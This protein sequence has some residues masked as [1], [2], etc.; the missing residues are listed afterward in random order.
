[1]GCPTCEARNSKTARF[2]NSCGELIRIDPGFEKQYRA[3][4]AKDRRGRWVKATARWGLALTILGVFGYEFTVREVKLVV[5]ASA[6]PLINAAV[7]AEVGKQLETQ[8]PVAVAQAES[9]GASK[10][11]A[12]YQRA[13]DDSVAK[14]RRFDEHLAALQKQK[15]AEVL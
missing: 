8:I 14:G 13:V 10:V 7:T 9:Q 2:C 11:Q 4:Q 3:I 5:D 6:R 1:M 15:E 12:A